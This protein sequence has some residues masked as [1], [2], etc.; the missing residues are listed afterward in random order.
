MNFVDRLLFSVVQEL[1][2]TDLALSD[3]QLGLLGGPAFAILYTTITF[4][5]ARLA[6][7][8]N[9]ITIISLAFSAWSI[10]TA[11][12][13]LAGRSAEHT[14]EL[15]SLMRNS[16]AVFCLKKQKSKLSIIHT[17]MEIRNT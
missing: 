1:I 15:Q 6:E 12:C 3:F 5:I 7:R 4:P 8:H 11:L 16:Y 13:G 2:K 17:N 10:M 9:R 14:S